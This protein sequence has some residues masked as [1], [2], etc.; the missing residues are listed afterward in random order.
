MVTVS[1]KASAA[2]GYGLS[3]LAASIVAIVGG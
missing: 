2:R 3:V 1:G